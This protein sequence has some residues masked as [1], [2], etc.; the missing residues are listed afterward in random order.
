M[1]LRFELKGTSAKKFHLKRTVDT[2]NE[3]HYFLN[4]QEV[5]REGY[6]AFLRSK[7]L[8]A[9][10]VCN[11]AIWQGA[12]ESLLNK[13]PTKLRNELEILSGSIFIKEEFDR[14][15]R[16]Y[17]EVDKK[18]RLKVDQ[19]ERIRADKKSAKMIKSAND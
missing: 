2:N 17:N 10:E 11:F 13:D 3:S 15:S 18:I 9:N 16:E 12:T 5:P 4:F 7:N 8:V 1:T 6:V 19:K 14:L